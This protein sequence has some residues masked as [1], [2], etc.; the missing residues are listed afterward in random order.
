MSAASATWRDCTARLRG[1]QGAA[2]PAGLTGP[3]GSA[4]AQPR[5][6]STMATRPGDAGRNWDPGVG[7]STL[8]LLTTLERGA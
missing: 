3:N 8:G 7:G 6:M 1:R 2:R 4:T 5:G